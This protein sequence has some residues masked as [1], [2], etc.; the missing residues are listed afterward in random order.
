[1][2]NLFIIFSLLIVNNSYSFDFKHEIMNIKLQSEMTF[3]QVKSMLQ[4][5][6]VMSKIENVKHDSINHLKQICMANTSPTACLSL[7]KYYDVN[8]D[9]LSSVDFYGKAC[10]QKVSIGC[11]L[12]GFASERRGNE[13]VANSAYKLGCDNYNDSA[14][15]KALAQNFRE[16]QMWSLSLSYFDKACKLGDGQ[17][18]FLAYEVTA[19]VGNISHRFKYYLQN[20][21]R[22]SHASSCLTLGYL[23]ESTSDLSTARSAYKDA[24]LLDIKEACDS[25]KRINEGGMLKNIKHH[26]L[27]KIN[28]IKE[29]FEIK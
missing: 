17:A 11:L 16:N 13:V 28:K 6:N 25:F 21:C 7:G 1:M 20:G 10:L 4:I 8:D 27:I 2:K 19:Y 9:L 26:F 5:D 23:G 24:C 14:N 29:Y 18:C 15:C 3:N 22:L 12:S